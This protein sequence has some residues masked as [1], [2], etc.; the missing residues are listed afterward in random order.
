MREGP[1]TPTLIPIDS[2]QPADYNPRVVNPLR[3]ELV[4]ASLVEL[5]WVLPAY[6][7]AREL[8]SG[9]QRTAAWK[10]LG[11]T[12]IPAVVLPDLPEEVRRGLNILFNLATNDFRRRT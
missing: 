8:L 12:T 5:G 10:A 9:H 1:V 11:H 4:K 6:V 3:F 2:V 7:S